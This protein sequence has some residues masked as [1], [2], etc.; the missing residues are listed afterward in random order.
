MLPTGMTIL[1]A[2]PQRLEIPEGLMN[3]GVHNLNTLYVE[4]LSLIFFCWSWQWCIMSSEWHSA[5]LQSNIDMLKIKL[6]RTSY[7]FALLNFSRRK[8]WLSHYMYMLFVLKGKH[9]PT[10]GTQDC[11]ELQLSRNLALK[12]ATLKVQQHQQHFDIEYNG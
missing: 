1:A 9:H 4:P 2:V 6:S 11:T 5:A 3:Y 8:G 12:G 7:A 10:V